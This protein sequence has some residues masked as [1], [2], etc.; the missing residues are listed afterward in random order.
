[1]KFQTGAMVVILAI[2][3]RG[4]AGFYTGS[5]ILSNCESVN[6]TEQSFCASYLGGIADATKLLV[7]AG[8][9]P[10]LIC[11]PGDATTDKL[12]EAFVEYAHENPGELD[13]VASATVIA[14]FMGAFP[15][16]LGETR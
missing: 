5:H 2:A 10:E 6:E 14:A 4:E 8:L 16:V 9:M 1:M 3:G 11:M 7:G 15:C 12:Q 13:E